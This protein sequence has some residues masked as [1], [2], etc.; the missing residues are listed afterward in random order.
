ML[1]LFHILTDAESDFSFPLWLEIIILSL[2]ILCL[3][4]LSMYAIMQLKL[5]WN[6]LN[7]PSPKIDRS[8]PSKDLPLVTVQLPMYNEL[9]VAERI[10]DRVARLNYPKENLQIQVLDDSTD[11][12]AQIVQRKIEELKKSGIDISLLHRKNRSGFKAGALKE[13]M[14]EVK[15]EFIAI[16]DADFIPDQNFLLDAIGKF[17]NPKVGVVQTHW[18]HLNKNYSLL[19]KLQA[20][21]LDGHFSIEQHGRKSG[22]H[23]I[24]FNG[25]AGIWRKSCIKDA[26][27]WEDDTLTEDLDLSYRA[28]L[29]GWKFVYLE[30]LES[31]AELPI[32]MAGL[33]SQQHRWMK[34]GAE[35]FKKNAGRIARS[36]IAR[37][38]DKLFGWMH[39]FNSSIFIVILIFGS[40][41]V[42]L[43][44]ILN[45]KPVLG[46]LGLIVSW[47]VMITLFVFY[48]ISYKKNNDFQWYHIP[49]Y[50][51]RF[52]Q[53]LSI[54]TG[55]SLNNTIA[56]IEGHLG[57]KSSFVRTPKFN[58]SKGVKFRGN[59]Y[60][61]G[62]INLQ[63]ILEGILAAIFWVIVIGF[64]AT[65]NYRL[66]LSYCLLSFGFTYVFAYSLIEFLSVKPSPV[67]EQ[68]TA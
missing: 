31:P 53:F 62:K 32:T 57:I 55:L 39:L 51:M 15:G 52:F 49:V 24:N 19:T 59:R 46:V 40:I 1:E 48:L 25:T 22:G 63:L 64:A 10:I 65:G 35:C 44:N 27:G 9:Y 34:G 4:V 7:H 37:P 2:Y 12:T 3:T 5:I 26:G 58:V 16:F 29:K 68:A 6:Y 11:E 38:I 66:A 45:D 47:V 50:T 61:K 28:Q 67:Y 43:I 41:G 54:S 60:H 42:P 23:F 21:G 8:A 30:N 56:S 33:K 18:G 36:K 17:D 20:F 14:P 13:A